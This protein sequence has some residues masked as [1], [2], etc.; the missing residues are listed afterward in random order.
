MR[1]S[2]IKNWRIREVKELRVLI[3]VMSNPE[4]CN[5]YDITLSTLLN[6]LRKYK[7]QRDK[8]FGEFLR[9]Q[10]GENNPN[11]KG[12]IS[13]DT[14][15]YQATQRERHPEHKLAR[16]AVY[17]ALKQGILVKPEECEDCHEVKPL[18]GHHPSYERDKWLDVNWLCRKCHRK[19]HP[20]H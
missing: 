2:R 5:H 20:D 4:L 11:W 3:N 19:R 18:Q 17:E 13:K 6:A 12:G 8:E 10:E 16:Q 15:R 9:K 1:V 7:I 14:A